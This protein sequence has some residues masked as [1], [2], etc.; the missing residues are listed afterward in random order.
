VLRYLGIVAR[1]ENRAP[2]HLVSNAA[3]AVIDV[4]SDA[5]DSVTNAVSSGVKSAENVLSDGLKSAEN[6]VDKAVDSTT[7]AVKSAENTVESGIKSTVEPG[8]GHFGAEEMVTGMPTAS[9]PHKGA[10]NGVLRWLTSAGMPTNGLFI[11]WAIMSALAFI[12]FCIAASANLGWSIFINLETCVA[13]AILA[14]NWATPQAYATISVRL[15]KVA[16]LIFRDGRPK[17]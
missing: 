17:F 3:A 12:N 5:A 16:K 1:E 15:Q 11:G 6:V 9:D 10:E 7:S 8:L 13:G 2:N 4:T 14:A